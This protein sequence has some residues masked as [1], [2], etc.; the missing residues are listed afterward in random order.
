MRNVLVFL[1][2]LIPACNAPYQQPRSIC[3][4]P[5]SLA[6]WSGTEVRWRGVVVGGYHGYALIAED[7]RRRGI[8]LTKWRDTTLDKAIRKRDFKD[9]LLRAEVS[10]KIIVHDEEQF[11]LVTDVQGVSFEPMTYEQVM[12][13]WT[14]KGF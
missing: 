8:G 13:F 7:C 14:S 2:L 5:P 1:F 4:L 9:G 12:A 3:D 6:S 10:G 11:L